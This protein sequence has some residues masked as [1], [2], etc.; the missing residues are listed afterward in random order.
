M[1][2]HET[3][4]SV[5]FVA[6]GHA[7][8]VKKPVTF[9]FLD[10]GT[11]ERRLEACREEVRVNEALAPGI[12]LGVLAIVPAG[13]GFRLQPDETSGAVEY[14]VH[15]L[16]FSE[17]ST[18][19]GA[20]DA[21][22]LTRGRVT[23]VAGVLAQFHRGAEIAADWGPDRLLAVWQRNIRELALADPPSDWHP[24]VAAT[25]ADAFV[26]AHA[27]ELKA[28]AKAGLARDGH[29]DLRCEHVLLEPSIR[30]VDRIE[31]D[32]GLRRTD[33]ASD[34][35]FLAMDLEASG[36]RWAAREL[37]SAYEAAGMNAGPH[38]LQSFF[39]AHRAFVRAKVSLIAAAERDGAEAAREHR[40]ASHTPMTP[41]GRSANWFAN[42][43]RSMPGRVRRRSQTRSGSRRGWC[44]SAAMTRTS[45]RSTPFAMPARSATAVSRRTATLSMS[46]MTANTPSRCAGRAR[47]SRCSTETQTRSSGCS[48]AT[49]ML[50]TSS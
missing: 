7:Y 20:I 12:Y 10:Y 38:A 33:I 49:S 18:M 37:I 14:V 43:S 11:L 1:S 2:V 50:R 13:D 48:A 9:G 40:L 34:L 22:E 16:A 39:A 25:F 35:A 42:C 31:F 45:S 47:G 41:T 3:H 26:A 15:M 19:K 46:A 30:V 44:A 6:G 8:K 36:Q 27:G 4:A 32:A 17:R 29:G 21:G 24:E 5:V 23:A 28:R